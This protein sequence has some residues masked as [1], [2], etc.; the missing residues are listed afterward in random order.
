MVIR[1]R[2]DGKSASGGDMATDMETSS[3]GLR[4]ERGRGVCSGLPIV[5]ADGERKSGG[6]SRTYIGTWPAVRKL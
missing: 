5:E 2:F 3:Y 1:Q 4:N 6:R